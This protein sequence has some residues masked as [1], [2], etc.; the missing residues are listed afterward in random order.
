[1]VAGD[2][3]SFQ[4]NELNVGHAWQMLIAEWWVNKKERRLGEVGKGGCFH[5]EKAGP[6]T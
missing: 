1:M 2:G 6:G 4:V 3:G 5:S